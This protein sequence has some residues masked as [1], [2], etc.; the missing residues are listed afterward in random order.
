MAGQTLP[1]REGAKK[2]VM[3]LEWAL[4]LGGR[5][6]GRVGQTTLAEGTGPLAPADP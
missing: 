2:S 3:E 6:P 1:S 4:R 5:V